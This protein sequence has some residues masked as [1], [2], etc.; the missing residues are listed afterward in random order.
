MGAGDPNGTY[1]LSAVAT[2][3]YPNG[4]FSLRRTLY[5][6][7]NE[8]HDQT[9]FLGESIEP[10][11]AA[12]LQTLSFRLTLHLSVQARW[13]APCEDYT[14]S[15]VELLGLFHQQHFGDIENTRL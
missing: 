7:G 8:S 10:H 2:S 3:P 1:G 13:D 12:S 6:D 5:P 15:D 9:V 4:P 14:G 11:R